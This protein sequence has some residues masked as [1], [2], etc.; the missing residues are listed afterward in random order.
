[1]DLGQRDAWLH[2]RYARWLD[3]LTRLASTATLAAFA[4]YLAGV[5]APAI[6]IADLPQLW[7][8]PLDEYLART[9]APTGWTWLGEIGRSDYLC[10]AGLSLFAFVVLLCNLSIVVPLAR[11]GDRLTAALVAAQALVLAIAASGLISG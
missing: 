8:L 9:G 4:L 1:V 10:Y 7:N 3:A 5:P 6:P 11:R 2:E